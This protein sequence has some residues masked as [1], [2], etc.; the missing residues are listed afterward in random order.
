M[1]PLIEGLHHVT[2]LGT[3]AQRNV[4]FYTG[5]LGLR[6]VKKTINF[7]APEVYHLYYGDEAGS[8]GTI[9]TFFPYGD[10]PRGRKGPG[11]LT[12][13]A[14]SIPQDALRFW[15]DRLIALGIPFEGP[16]QRFSEMVLRLEDYDG[17]G[18]E[19][20][21]A[22]ADPRPGRASGSIP[23]EY[24]VRGFHSVTLH[25]SLADPTVSLLA[26][27]MQHQVIA[28]EGDRTRLSSGSGGPGAWIDVLHTPGAPRAFQGAGSVHHVA[29]NTASDATQ[30]EIREALLSAGMQVTP[31]LDR[32]Y[33]H[34]VYFREPGRIL[35]E[36]A[37][38]PPG[39]T[40]DEPLD[41]LGGS[42]KLPAWEEPNRSRIEAGLESFTVKTF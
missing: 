3:T 31:V 27:T 25:E 41:S 14:F 37:T 32:N 34:S 12:Y 39:F 23:A 33:F 40:A 13:T 35:F 8:P 24:A 7:D 38:A 10:M 42:L 17:M 28:Q 6:L 21:T 9:M 1:K 16:S 4:D 36:I 18:V 2:A 30:L 19:L 20:V 5:V 26:G 22:A 15:M 29:F 11:Q